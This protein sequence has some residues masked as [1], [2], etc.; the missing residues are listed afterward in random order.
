MVVYLLGLALKDKNVTLLTVLFM[1]CSLKSDSSTNQCDVRKR[2][3]DL[4]QWLSTGGVL[5]HDLDGVVTSNICP[6]SLS[7]FPKVV[8]LM[9]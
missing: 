8:G 5:K 2:E 7:Y 1:L 9:L 4:K 6:H 3:F